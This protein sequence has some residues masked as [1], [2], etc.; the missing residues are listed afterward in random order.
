MSKFRN[1]PPQKA[2]L[3]RLVQPSNS[4]E[5][6]QFDALSSSYRSFKFISRVS[7]KDYGMHSK[8]LHKHK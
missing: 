8:K 7:A 1:K 2:E 3:E 5:A 4:H 6:L